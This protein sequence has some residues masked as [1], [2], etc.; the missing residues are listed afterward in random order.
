MEG[1]D[2]LLTKSHDVMFEEVLMWL[3][4]IIEGTPS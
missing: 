1:D 4:P 3:K 2:H